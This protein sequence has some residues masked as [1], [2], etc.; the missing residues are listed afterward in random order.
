[1]FLDLSKTYWLKA[2]PRQGDESIYNVI[3]R[4]FE[5]AFYAGGREASLKF[6]GYE[7]EYLVLELTLGNTIEGFNGSRRWENPSTIDTIEQLKR[8]GSFNGVI[9]ESVTIEERPS[10]WQN[11]I[12]RVAAV[13]AELPKEIGQ[14][15][16]TAT[17]P[18]AKAAPYFAF[19]IVLAAIIGLYFIAR[20]EGGGISK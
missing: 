2:I 5:G 16:A 12:S 15:V 19:G 14:A 1:M 9:F 7:G 20:I 13:A 10:F 18:T 8:E 4:Q 11:K 6:V 3:C 17:A